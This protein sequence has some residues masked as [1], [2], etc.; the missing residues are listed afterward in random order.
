M[1]KHTAHRTHRKTRKRG[2]MDPPSNKKEE[3]PRARQISRN[4]IESLRQQMNA[5]YEMMSASHSSSASSSTSNR[6]IIIQARAPTGISMNTQTNGPS[7][8]NMAIQTNTILPNRNANEITTE[9]WIERQVDIYKLQIFADQPKFR[10]QFTARIEQLA[11][12]IL[13]IYGLCTFSHDQGISSGQI[14]S[15]IITTSDVYAIYTSPSVYMQPLRVSHPVLLYHFSEPLSPIC[16]SMLKGYCDESIIQ[17]QHWAVA[18]ITPLHKK[19]RSLI[20][21]IPGE[22]RHGDSW[23]V[24]K[25]GY[26]PNSKVTD[27]IRW[28]W[29]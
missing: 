18:V 25:D 27:V 14:I 13:A 4:N 20:Y 23:P 10:E 8:T 28:K 26:G 2:G 19:F 5:M 1:K 3:I 17:G 12:P 22:K 7:V 9:Q 24:V 16:I 21:S 15:Y 11:Q 6:P 29:D